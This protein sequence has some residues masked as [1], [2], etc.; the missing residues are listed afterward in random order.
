MSLIFVDLDFD[1]YPVL[2]GCL[3]HLLC[4]LDGASDVVLAGE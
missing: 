1:C 4:F 3:G 2:A